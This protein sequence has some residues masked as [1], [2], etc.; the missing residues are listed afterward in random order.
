MDLSAYVSDFCKTF[1]SNLKSKDDNTREDA[2]V[3]IL[4]LGKQNSDQ[5]AVSSITIYIK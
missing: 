3:A 1:C 2:I 4:A 5:G